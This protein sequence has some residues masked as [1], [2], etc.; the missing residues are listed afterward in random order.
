MT[1][2]PPSSR[3]PLLNALIPVLFV[4][5]WSTGFIGG[6]FGMPYAE[7]YTFLFLRYALVVL[8]I[9]GIAWAMRAP[10]PRS[11]REAGHIGVSGFLM[12]G[13]NIGCV[14]DSIYHGLPA[15]VASLIVG[16]QPLLTAAVVGPILGEKVSR[17]QW[18]G[19]ILG[20]VGV[21]LVVGEKLS[22]NISLV[23]VGLAG[24]ALLGITAG[25]VYQKRFCPTFD[26]RTGLTIQ[27]LV[28][29]TYVGVLAL[30]LETRHVQWSGEF[31]FAL[32]WLVL[33]LSIGAM[34]LLFMMI[35]RGAASRTAALFYL[36]PASTALI[37]FFLFDERL[38][39]LALAGMVL[40]AIGVFLAT[41]TP[42]TAP[43]PL[44]AVDAA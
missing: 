7:P 14:F 4:P 33:V 8:L 38:G 27:H 2:T 31:V 11:W 29:V 9:G 35:R 15:G 28:A 34:S 26:L 18:A 39:V 5:I 19:L 22:T 20:L 36:V 17:G 6:K 21:A 23:A 42:K 25:T 24:I 40:T 37:A 3:T 10:W 1:V 43:S 30:T 44:T 32:G 41:R 13:V 16:L 12:H